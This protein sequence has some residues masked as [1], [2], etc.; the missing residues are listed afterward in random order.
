MKHRSVKHALD[1]HGYTKFVGATV[2]GVPALPRW[3]VLFLLP[4]LIAL[5][6]R[7][8]QPAEPPANPTLLL[9]GN[10]QFALAHNDAE[11]ERLANFYQPGYDAARFQRITVPSNWALQGF[12]PP[13]YGRFKDE[14][15]EGFYIHRFT[16]P[17]TWRDKRILLHF[18][19]VW[20]SAEVWLNG[21]HLGRHDSGFTSFSFDVTKDLQ[22]GA[23]NVL[24][25]RVRQVTHDY[26]FDTNDDWS[27]G[28]I[29]RDVSLETM[30]KFRWIDRVD[31]QTVFDSQFQDADLNIRAM[32]GDAR[33]RKESEAPYSLLVSLRKDGA[34]IQNAKIAIPAH[35]GTDRDIALKLH[36]QHPLHWTAETPALYDLQ[37]ELLENGKPTHVR[38]LAVGFR[39]ISTA[40][41][42]FRINGQAVKLRGVDRHDEYPDGGRATT[43][44]NWTQ[45]LK[46]MKAANINFIRCSHYPPAAG[47]LDLCDRL[48][49][50]VDDEVPMG[51]GGNDANDPSFADAVMLRSY[52]AVSRDINH[53]SIVL[54]SIGN[55]DP[56][57]SLH[58]AA[59]RTVKGLDPTRPVL[60]P[61]RAEQWLPPEIDILAPHYFTAAQYDELSG[62]SARP[63]VTT[64]YTHAYGTDGFGGLQERWNALTRHPAGA[65]GAIW[66]WADQGLKVTLDQPGGG[67]KTSLE[68]NPGGMDGTVSSYREPQRD[69]WET[70]AVYAQTYPA[71]G[72]TSFVPG[73]AS[74][75]I[76]I[77]NDF[78]FTNLDTVGIGWQLM[79]DDRELD[80]GTARLECEPHATA[81]LPLRLSSIHDAHPGIAYY[82]WFTFTRADGSEI[83]RRSVEL[84]PAGGAVPVAITKAEPL[85]VRRGKVVVVKAG[86]ASYTFDP[87]IAQLASASLNGVQVIDG[88]SFTIWRPLGP[89]E[90]IIVGKDRAKQLPDLNRYRT[91]V[92]SW[93]VSESADGVEIDARA[94]HVI[95]AKNHFQVSYT[96]SIGRDGVLSI[97]YSVKPQVEAEWLPL[98]GVTLRTPP[99]LTHLRWLGLGPLDAY[100]NE[101]AAAIFGVWSGDLG[102]PTA[103]GVKATRWAE[104]SGTSGVVLKIEGCPYIRAGEGSGLQA[105]SAVVG[106]SAKTRRPE[107]PEDRLD[108]TAGSSFDGGFRVSLARA[109]PRTAPD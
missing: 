24:A 100:P 80:H 78:D 59:I 29:Y 35:P 99:A 10:W 71:I 26:L 83:T 88:A 6:P 38:T 58:M 2:R 43:P 13:H 3:R 16:V 53:P 96:Y 87:Q 34:E 49:M 97:H 20:T 79:A 56:L 19:G 40:G 85:S 21:K 81:W 9:N 27:L 51:D 44:E 63:V 75:R 61:W 54:W 84:L 57:T 66:M 72:K 4:I 23:E 68:L 50:Y 109:T 32:I 36:V 108:T 11:A 62:E 70:K 104:L 47:F 93:K 73:Q 89:S 31:A 39:Q 86:P 7:T 45:D 25:V 1:P 76:P 5:G 28:G 12:E 41:G 52:E 92:E 74:V 102:G 42:I 77:R 18:G 105:L 8:A 48:G 14:A 103:T 101:K 37:V 33:P 69:Y 67:K 30:P 107:N 94:N 60:M 64:E 17:D 98:V 65:G 15:S 55:E 90:V 46:L 91:A 22:P 82:A 95:D 106:R